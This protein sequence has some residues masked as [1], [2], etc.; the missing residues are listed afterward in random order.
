MSNVD[1]NGG[2][3]DTLF[4]FPCKFPI[5]AMGRSIIGIE[6]SIVDIVRRHTE[7]IDIVSVRT[8]LSS[9]ARY[10]GVT[11]TITARSKA[12]LDAIYMDLTAHP[13]VL[14]SY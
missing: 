5:K 2:T 1:G 11:I 8:R 7:E 9:G 10:I 6:A 3:T 4:E 13:D 14:M 12:Q